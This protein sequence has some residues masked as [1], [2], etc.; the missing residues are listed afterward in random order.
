MISGFN[1]DINQEEVAKKTAKAPYVPNTDET[2]LGQATDEEV[3]D[4]VEDEDD[5]PV[6][7]GRFDYSDF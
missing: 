2:Q 1:V 6:Y 3:L 4:L 5:I 7:T